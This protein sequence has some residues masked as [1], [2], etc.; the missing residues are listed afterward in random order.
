M[1]IRDDTSWPPAAVFNKLG[2][3]EGKGVI[4]AARV[5]SLPGARPTRPNPRCLRRHSVGVHHIGELETALGARTPTVVSTL[6]P[7]RL[8]RLAF[9]P[10]LQHGRPPTGRRGVNTVHGT[11]R[12]ETWRDLHIAG[13]PNKIPRLCPRCHY[14]LSTSGALLD[15][16]TM[17]GIPGR[18]S[19]RNG[20]TRRDGYK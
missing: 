16:H 5:P 20:K 8:F 18:T 17:L 7:C 14:T 10:H 9:Y 4:P 19:T 11:L 1:P 12:T 13:S 2:R 3:A 15:Q 6:P